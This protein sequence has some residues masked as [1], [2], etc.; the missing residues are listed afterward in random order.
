MKINKRK[1]NEITCLGQLKVHI[2]E[3]HFFVH[4]RSFYIELVKRLNYLLCNYH[5]LSSRLAVC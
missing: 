5:P 1:K 4:P 2:R 3:G